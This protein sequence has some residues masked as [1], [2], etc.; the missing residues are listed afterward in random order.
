MFLVEVCLKPS[1]TARLED[2]KRSVERFVYIY[3][4]Y[5]SLTLILFDNW[6]VYVC[7][8]MLEKRSMS[9]VDG[10]VLIPADDLFLVE[11]VQSICICDTG[12]REDFC[13]SC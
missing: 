4:S 11:N 12:I 5:Y 13:I 8:R 6:I 9:Y 7:S 2:V 10:L 3:F 1:S